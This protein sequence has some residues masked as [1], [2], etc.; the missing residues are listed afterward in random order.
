[1]ETLSLLAAVKES[2]WPETVIEEPAP[3]AVGPADDGA[4]V[5]ENLPVTSV[6][7]DAPFTFKKTTALA[8]GLEEMSTTRPES[9]TA[10]AKEKRQATPH[11]NNVPRYF[12]KNPF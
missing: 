3:T 5:N 9:V 12:I 8:T 11:A 4:N 10:E 1:M 6:V 2:L 7:A